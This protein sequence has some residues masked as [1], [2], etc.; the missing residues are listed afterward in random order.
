L[1]LHVQKSI[2]ESHVK[3]LLNRHHPPSHRCY[4]RRFLPNSPVGVSVFSNFDVS[5]YNLKTSCAFLL[6]FRQWMSLYQRTMLLQLWNDSQ[7]WD[8]HFFSIEGIA[9]EFHRRPTEF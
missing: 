8:E 7:P 3:W 6:W 9:T 1:W 4:R 5:E 2:S